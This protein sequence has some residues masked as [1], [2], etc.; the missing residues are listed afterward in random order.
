MRP[1]ADASQTIFFNVNPSRKLRIRGLEENSK[2]G[3]RTVI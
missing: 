3:G 1:I 2:Q